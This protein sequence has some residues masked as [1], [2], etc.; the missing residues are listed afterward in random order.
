MSFYRGGNVQQDSSK[1][2]ALHET[3]LVKL[4]QND[5]ILQSIMILQTISHTMITWERSEKL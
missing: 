5:N 2:I 1:D 4:V 3:I